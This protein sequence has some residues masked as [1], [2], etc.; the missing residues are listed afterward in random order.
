MIA[1]G[2]KNRYMKTGSGLMMVSVKQVVGKGEARMDL[3]P[4]CQLS[5]PK[6]RRKKNK[7]TELTSPSSRL[8]HRTILPANNYKRISVIVE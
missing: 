2:S 4:C 6:A 8:L 5:D 7:E 3:G 1:S